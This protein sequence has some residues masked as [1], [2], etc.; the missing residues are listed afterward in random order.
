MRKQYSWAEG[1]RFKSDPAAVS[2]RIAKLAKAG[3]VTPDAFI[4]DAKNPKSPQHID[5]QWDVNEAAMEHWRYTARNMIRSIR[6][7]TEEAPD[8]IPR[9][10]YI[11][12]SDEIGGAG[13]LSSELVMSRADLR[14][15]ALDQAFSLLEGVQR[16]FNELQELSGVFQA[17]EEAKR[18]RGKNPRKGP[19]KRPR[20]GSPRRKVADYAT[21]VP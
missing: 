12:V 14:Q 17:I 15:Q 3:P 11:H 18:A 19:P 5:F 16:R 9:R 8:A 20:G 4:E 10:L 1:V 21:A 7:I 6:V 13:Y 2:K